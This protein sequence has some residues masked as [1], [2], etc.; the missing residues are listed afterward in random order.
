MDNDKT[1]TSSHEPPVLSMGS[2]ELPPRVLVADDSA[3]IRVALVRAMPEQSQVTEASNGEEAWKLL[4]EKDEIE[5]V[6]TDLDMP[7]LNGYEL[8]E[9]IRSSEISRI[10]SMPVIVVTGA[11]DT[12]AKSRAFELG[13]NDFI[14]KNADKIE[15][16]ARVRAHHKL[17]LLIHELED[18]RKILNDQAN[19]DALTKLTNRRAFFVRSSEALELMRR[20]EQPFSM[21][22]IDVDHFKTINDTY[23]HQCGDNILVEV[24]QILTKNIRTNDILARIGGEEFAIAAPYSNRLA[25]VVLAER[26]RKAVESA[27]F[28]YNDTRVAVT[29][30]IGVVAQD[31]NLPLDIDQLLARA[32]ARL[33]IAKRRGRNRLC[34]TDSGESV[35]DYPGDE[36][37]CPKLDDALTMIQHGNAQAML[38]HLPCLLDKTLDLFRLANT[39]LDAGM[40]VELLETQI[41]AL[42][43]PAE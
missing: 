20:H 36:V 39:R 15:I 2:A 38:V 18:S 13:A 12:K 35:D 25:A 16:R 30:S 4:Q 14:S 34:A 19:T 8:L 42:V 1:N 37:S 32:D 33:Y 3:T 6:I 10:A 29:V 21:L 23:G 17:A 22:M 43:K 11:E 40:P 26:L 24:A 28:T 5:L 9:R 27:E 7:R 31:K 41:K